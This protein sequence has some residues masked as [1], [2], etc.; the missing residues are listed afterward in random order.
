MQNLC[1]L[2]LII[3]IGASSLA[4][5][6]ATVQ[7]QE[8]AC[9][10]D[11]VVQSGDTLSSIAGRFYGDAQAY[12]RISD[13]TNDQREN[14][15]S[16]ASITNVNLL[17]IGWKLCI[18]GP[19]DGT[20]SVTSQSNVPPE[21]NV[22]SQ[23]VAAPSVPVPVQPN[24]DL[25][26]D[27][28]HP[29]MIEYMRQQTY[30]G[31]E[32]TIEQQLEAGINYSRYVAS[33][34]SEGN[35]IFALLTVPNGAVPATG[36]P[37]I[38]FNHGYIPPTIYR[39]TERYV[40]YQDAFA[41]NGYITFK[42]DYRGHGFSEGES[43]SGSGSPAYTVDVLNALTSLKAYP[44]VDTDRMGMWG[45]SM[46][47]AITL[48]SM[49]IADDIKVGVIWAG[50]VGSMDQ[51][52][53]RWARRARENPSPERSQR[54]RWRQELLDAYGT[55]E[56]NPEF[57]GSISP[58]TYV[59]DL[60]GPVLLQHAT[61]DAT[62]PV[63]FSQRLNEQILAVGGDVEYIEYQGDDHNISVNLASALSSAVAYFDR[64]LK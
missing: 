10:S 34:Q 17:E 12:Q 16:Y 64:Y 1:Q 30:P 23:A 14:D 31:S 47:G 45:H 49:V 39:T 9:E 44:G 61:G 4:I 48:R 62:V 41:R 32:I 28:M 26:L 43:A 20:P 21:S 51:L 8:I 58:N 36:W 15:S 57:W 53:E 35:K 56:E 24:I 25:S 22:Q 38:V 19:V 55:L 13:A 11:V 37:T 7:A 5:P 3:L 52:F 46:G 63:A 27:E 2:L 60:S 18:P 50:T 6:L 40:A 42:A 54:G 59:A 29:L 33:Y